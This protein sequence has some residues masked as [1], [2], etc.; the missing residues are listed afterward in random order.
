MIVRCSMVCT[1]EVNEL[2]SLMERLW[3][4]QTI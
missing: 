1:N 4:M 3:A 2:M